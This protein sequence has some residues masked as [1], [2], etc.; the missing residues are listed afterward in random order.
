MS[1]PSAI[2]EKQ[3]YAQRIVAGLKAVVETYNKKLQK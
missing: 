1:Q 2:H 3:T